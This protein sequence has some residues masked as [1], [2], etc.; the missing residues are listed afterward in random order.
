MESPQG[1]QEMGIVV[2]SVS[3]VL[4]I[5]AA[6]IEPA[7]EFGTAIRIDFIAGMGK[8]AGRFVVILAVDRVLAL[9]ELAVLAGFGQPEPAS[10]D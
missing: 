5:A 10:A 8:L 6:D 4:E 7:P 9:A 2:D 3:E 1:K